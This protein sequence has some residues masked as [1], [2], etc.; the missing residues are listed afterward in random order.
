M[1]NSPSKI[2]LNVSW[3]NLIATAIGDG[4]FSDIVVTTK[5]D[6]GAAAVTDQDE[7]A[8]QYW[9]NLQDDMMA[10]VYPYVYKAQHLWKAADDTA[11]DALG[12]GDDLAVSDL[13]WVVSLN[14]LWYVTAVTGVSSSTWAQ[15]GGA[16]GGGGLNGEWRFST[17]TTMADPTSGRIRFNNV[18]Q[19]A[20]TEMAVSVTT[21]NGANVANILNNLIGVSFRMYIQNQTAND[22]YHVVTID[23]AATDNTTWVQYTITVTNSGATPIVNN[24]KCLVIFASEASA[25][26]WSSVLAVG[27]ATGATSPIIS[28]GQKILGELELALEA[29]GDAGAATLTAAAATSTDATGGSAALTAGTGDG[30]GTGGVSAVNGGLGGA[31]NGDGG[32]S[33]V[34]GGTGVG[35]G[36][37]GA[38]QVTGGAAGAT[39]TGGGVTVTAAN[40]NGSNAGGAV[41]VASGD[42]GA[43]NAAGSIT[44]QG[45]TGGS[46]APG[47]TLNLTGGVSGVSG[48]SGGPV[49]VKG[50]AGSSSTGG[51]SSVT[52][53]AGDGAGNGGSSQLNGGAGGATGNGGA[54]QIKGG[55]GGST[56]GDGGDVTITG[57]IP[58]LGNSDGGN[59]S[60]IPKAGTGS[61]TDG[62]AYVG[63][64]TIVAEVLGGD[65]ITATPTD[66]INGKSVSVA[67]IVGGQFIFTSEDNIPAENDAFPWQFISSISSFAPVSTRADIK[68]TS[69]S[70]LEIDILDDGVS[71]FSS[72]FL[73]IAASG[74]TATKVPLATT[75]AAD[76]KLTINI[77][78]GSAADWDGLTISLQ[79]RSITT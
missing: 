67:A 3:A 75:I 58:Q 32:V 7:A 51:F 14:E 45:G 44:A 15:V 46:G 70:S 35:A 72:G 78:A 13:C 52:G 77:E 50:G 42:G 29:Q 31:T 1:A 2:D 4:T 62:L 79:G 9:S 64:K 10:A 49:I 37:G 27:A 73:T 11:R 26:P 54:A 5:F 6:T 33:R 63:T 30:T 59:V 61:G 36:D 8:G 28:T 43:G 74:S 66:S 16:G 47:G 24:G 65:G 53:G 20:A 38:A 23:S 71:I 21:D 55:A 18:T 76:S 34:L 68:T 39:G 40:S 69:S 48:P 17:T 12:S 41:V 60:L 57:G 25:A 22:Q 56:S 19:S